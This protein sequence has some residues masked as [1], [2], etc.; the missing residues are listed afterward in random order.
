MQGLQRASR[1]SSWSWYSARRPRSSS[2]A[3]TVAAAASSPARAAPPLSGTARMFP[4]PR[5]SLSRSHRAPEASCCALCICHTAPLQPRLRPS[6][7]A[8]KADNMMRSYH[9]ERLRRPSG[10]SKTEQRQPERWVCHGRAVAR[11]GPGEAP[12]AG[13]AARPL[14]P[15]GVAACPALQRVVSAPCPSAAACLPAACW[16]P[17]ATPLPCSRCCVQHIHCARQLQPCCDLLLHVF[18]KTCTRARRQRTRFTFGNEPGLG[19]AP[20]GA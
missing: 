9:A 17:G 19:A 7:A 10:Q 18:N 16:P 12:I 4:L 14:A 20:T 5:P 1:C 13:S 2:Y 8:Y 3:S 15:G 11:P 6:Q